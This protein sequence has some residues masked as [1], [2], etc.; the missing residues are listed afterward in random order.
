[1]R[2]SGLRFQRNGYLHAERFP[3][4][5]RTTHH[6][7]DWDDFSFAYEYRPSRCRWPR[8]EHCTH[9]LRVEKRR[10]CE[11]ASRSVAAAALGI[12]FVSAGFVKVASTWWRDG[13]LRC[14][15]STDHRPGAVETFGVCSFVAAPGGNLGGF[16]RSWDVCCVRGAR[17]IG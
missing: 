10:R 15:S 1:M 12:R 17:S 13:T 4:R 14:C 16:V 2:I 9:V 3:H 8:T 6:R 11:R 7:I 5:R